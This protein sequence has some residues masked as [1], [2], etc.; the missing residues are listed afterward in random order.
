MNNIVAE[1]R[2]ITQ[3]IGVPYENLSQAYL[4]AET[5]LTSNQ[6]VIKFK[7]QQG[8][9]STGTVTERL[10]ALN[11]QFVITHLFFGL[12]SLGASESDA[13]HVKSVIETYN[14]SALDLTTPANGEAYYNG[15]FEFTID[16]KEY[17]PQFPMRAFKRVPDTQ[18]ATDADYTGSG[19]DTVDGYG[20]GLFGPDNYVTRGE[21]VKM[22]YNLLIMI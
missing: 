20:N 15:S 21:A 1:K 12:K 14:S 18:T 5:V 16:R 10:L 22:L 4:R 3:N 9:D 6:S 19:I 13:A 17:I 7:I 2:F 11:D 8:K